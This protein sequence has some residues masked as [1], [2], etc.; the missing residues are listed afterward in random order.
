MPFPHPSFDFPDDLIHFTVFW[1]F[2]PFPSSEW[3][4]IIL[5]YFSLSWE[6]RLFLSVEKHFVSFSIIS[7][8]HI[9]IVKVVCHLLLYSISIVSIP[10]LRWSNLRTK[11]EVS[12]PRNG[13][14]LLLRF[15]IIWPSCRQLDY[16]VI[17]KAVWGICIFPIQ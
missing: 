10:F 12:H 11:Q 3:F 1:I 2:L 7:S 5:P 17:Q 6:K 14:R 15:R 9:S 13:S 8:L 16:L 4:A